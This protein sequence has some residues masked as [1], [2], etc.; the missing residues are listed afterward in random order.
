M[1]KFVLMAA[2]VLIAVA[3]AL[4]LSSGA[5]G[6]VGAPDGAAGGAA[7]AQSDDPLV[8]WEGNEWDVNTVYAI[9]REDPHAAFFPY[10][11]E[12]AAKEFHNYY[13]ERSPYYQTLNGTWKFFH[14]NRP[15]DRPMDNGVDSFETLGF[16]ASGWDDIKVPSNW[17][18]NWNEDGTLKYDEPMYVNS[19]VPWNKTGWNNTGI[20]Y[21]QAPKNFNPVGTYRRTFTVD[22]AWADRDVFLYLDGVDSNCYIWVNGQ[23][24][25]YA[26][27]SYSGKIFNITP[28]IDYE[29][30]NAIAVQVFRWSAGSWY[31]NQDMLRLSGIFRDIYLVAQPKVA[32]YDV[33]VVTAPVVDDVYDGAWDLSIKALLR[34]LGASAAMKGGARVEAKL[35]DA[36]DALVGTS[37][38]ASPA[39]TA[40][41]NMLGNEFVG[42]DLSS[43]ITVQK[44]NLWSAEHPYL[45]KLVATLS[46][47]GAMLSTTC[48]RVG[49]REIKAVNI[50]N[51]QDSRL[52]INGTRMVLFGADLHEN[53]PNT[54]KVASMDDIRLDYQ[55]M[56]QHNVNSVRMSHYPKA[57]L[58]YDL[59]DEY[60]IYIMD[61]G[62]LENH[63][64]TAP[65][66]A[67]INV[68]L[69][70]LVDRENNMVS[71]QINR[72]SVY[73]WSM[74]NETS[75][76]TAANTG[77]L[78][79]VHQK[80]PTR[81]RHFQSGNGTVS[82]GSYNPLT[83][84]ELFSGFYGPA[85]STSQSSSGGWWQNVASQLRPAVLGEYAHA[86][87]NSNGNLDSFIE[88]SDA[89]PKSVLGYIWEWSDHSLWTPVPGDPGQKFFGFDGDWGPVRDQR[90]FCTDG[91]VM[92]DRTPYPQMVEVKHAYRQL[93]ATVKAP[94]PEGKSP[95]DAA[96]EGGGTFSVNNKYLFTNADEFDMSW[97]LTKN[98]VVV[99]SGKS[100]LDVAPAPAGVVETHLSPIVPPNT[101][102]SYNY[103]GP[104]MTSK[105]FPV[106]FIAPQ[107]VAPGDEYFFNVRFSLRE[108]A[109]W[110]DAGFAVSDSQIPV[111]FG[112]DAKT[113][114]PY[115]VGNLAV[116]ESDDAITV[117]GSDFSVAISKADGVITQY[118]F[119][120]RDMLAAG[121]A[122]NFW[123]APTD[124]EYPRTGTDYNS[125]VAWRTVARDRQLASVEVSRSGFSVTV[126][127]KGSFPST[128]PGTYAMAYT[129]YPNGE[130]NVSN[131]FDFG[132]ITGNN[133][134]LQEIGNMMT[135]KSDFENLTWFG[136]G[137]GES[138]NDRKWGNLVGLW[139]GTVTDQYFPYVITQ[140]T[141]NK[142][143]TR[144]F[145]LTDDDGFGLV[146]KSD[147]QPVE[148]NALHYTP[149]ELGEFRYKHPY[150]A[151]AIEDI[152]LRVNLTSVG[153][154]GN[155]SWGRIPEDQYRPMVGSGY[156][157]APITY[158]YSML[159]VEELDVGEAMEFYKSVYETNPA[160]IVS[161]IAAPSSVVLHGSGQRI[162][163]SISI[164]QV[165]ASNMF[166]VWAQFDGAKLDY[167]DSA[168]MLPAE[169]G[170][171]FLVEPQFDEATGVYTATIAL[172]RKDAVFGAGADAVPLL[173]ASF[174]LKGAVRA[175][176]TIS[177]ALAA[178]KVVELLPNDQTLTFDARLDPKEA[179][180]F[181]ASVLIYDA[182]GNG[183]LDMADV[184]LVI[185][186]FYM[187][188]DAD[189]GWDEAKLY[190]LNGDGAVNLT[191]ILLLMVYLS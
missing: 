93:T 1:K 59:A 98:G 151:E 134:Y 148:F 114:A 181:I 97:E 49:F 70:G 138:Y 161:G 55:L 121:P 183:L 76:G 176:D 112:Q 34:D 88:I 111:D 191:D 8:S 173:E 165:D 25:G 129:I 91:M 155:D 117:S 40:R 21:P 75:L 37:T 3:M 73:C 166:Q 72:P 177:A 175:N 45:Y 53:N 153:V 157:D 119:K 188:T 118:K 152:C 5:S 150:E 10:D 95:E 170:A 43:V 2:V 44:P 126:T 168:I 131:E 96:L 182:D 50:G 23:K 78:T 179:A 85:Y 38:M 136:R 39:F 132:N 18:V 102:A 171:S 57:R 66:A 123:R 82:A 4:P 12:G 133:R 130:V 185:Y 42:A 15:A 158:S 154:G 30:P 105:D 135:V 164:A 186:K 115:P 54:G 89:M 31:E 61:E 16:D 33:N 22:P 26:E 17:Q 113:P 86:M 120:G 104:T 71:K 99:Q 7:G 14:V 87:G 63:G 128:R 9:N 139:E 68:W 20:T 100:V 142:V 60:G 122:P 124:N 62:N 83:A 84:P 29:G 125:F 180:T 69:P 149:E 163:Y 74:G 187:A 145:A 167:A 51:R 147:G 80:D 90:N 159:P 27:D 190:D 77:L 160:K 174:T 13:P 19:T 28:F 81:V 65:P 46:S 103:V 92:A 32:L 116:S 24:A 169:L 178:V 48:I 146:V 58:Y 35:Y 184:A 144:W 141:G 137:P 109:V 108:D 127:A 36:N 64:L 101:T 156:N 106:P 79:F 67:S 52:L 6:A 107:D 47:D 189:P 110:A 172:L 11:N 56:K 94:T 162:S 41:E 143:G 140:E